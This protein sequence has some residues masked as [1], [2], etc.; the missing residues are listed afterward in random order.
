MDKGDE[1]KARPCSGELSSPLGGP[2]VP[3]PGLRG[4]HASPAEDTCTE[5]HVCAHAHTHREVCTHAPSRMCTR[6]L[7]HT[8]VHVC[9]QPRMLARTRT[10]SSEHH[11]A[12]EANLFKSKPPRSQPTPHLPASFPADLP[13]PGRFPAEHEEAQTPHVSSW[14]SL[15]CQ[16]SSRLGQMLPLCT[17]SFVFPA[18]CQVPNRV[19]GVPLGEAEG[20]GSQRAEGGRWACPAGQ[21][22][23]GAMFTLHTRAEES[24]PLVHAHLGGYGQRGRAGEGGLSVG[25]AASASGAPSVSAQAGLRA[26]TRTGRC[27]PD[28]TGYGLCP[29]PLLPTLP[30]LPCGAAPR[31]LCFTPGRSR[32][33]Q[34]QEGGLRG[35]VL[36]AALD[37]SEVWHPEASASTAEPS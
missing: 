37:P 25:H 20:R 31:A 18:P 2:T 13:P 22:P 36:T 15:P 5:G 11:R 8:C 7:N 12:Q 17:V 4:K 24:C 27:G 33:C 35:R 29:G 1:E 10:R 34:H 26:Q 19:Q 32:N 23:R 3:A 28:P 6:V 30:A 9:T 14:I 16:E 21:P